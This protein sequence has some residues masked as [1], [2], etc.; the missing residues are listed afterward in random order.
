MC[1]CEIIMYKIDKEK[2]KKI[3]T[4]ELGYNNIQAEIFCDLHLS[5]V[6]NELTK[7]VK[8]YLEDRTIIDISIHGLSIQELMKVQHVDFLEAIFY[9]NRILDDDVVDKDRLVELLRRPPPGQK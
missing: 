6:H 1:Y 2:V 9:L 8:R 5:S 4:E 7:A 3:L